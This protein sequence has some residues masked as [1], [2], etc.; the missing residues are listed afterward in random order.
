MAGRDSQA[1][2]RAAAFLEEAARRHDWAA[3][4]WEDHGNPGLAA[5]ERR[6][7]N[8]DRVTATAEREHA[9]D[10]RYRDE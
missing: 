2:K 9:L 6:F 7:A 5:R 3:Q 8:N 1:H 10:D 4:Y